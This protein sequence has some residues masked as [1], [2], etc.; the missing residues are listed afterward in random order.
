MSDDDG[1]VDVHRVDRR[2]LS[3]RTRVDELSVSI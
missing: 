2:E 1:T 3:F